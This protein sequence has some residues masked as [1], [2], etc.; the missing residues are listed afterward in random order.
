MGHERAFV[1]VKNL[2]VTFPRSERPVLK[3]VSFEVEEGDFTLITG[4]TGAGKTTL[5][6]TLAG[7]IPSLIPAKVEGS[8][9]LGNR[10]PV[11]E[12]L[13][14]MAGFLGIV[15]QDPEAQYVMP[16]VIEEAYFPA[17]N[18]LLPRDEVARRAERALA[19][20][21]LSEYRAH[22]V[23]TLSTGLKQRLAL[24]T[25]LVLDPEILL[26][27]E[28]TAHIDMWTAREI[29]RVL[30]ELKESGKTILVVEHRIELAEGLAD[31]VVYIERDGRASV[32]SSVDEMIRIHGAERLVSEGIWVPYRYIL[33]PRREIQEDSPAV[34]Q[35]EEP[36]VSVE[37]LTVRLGGV[38]VLDNVTLTVPRGRVA[39]I[40]GPNGSGKTTLLKVLSGILRDFQGSV[41]VLG[42]SPRPD[43]V[44]FVAQ[45][46]EL[47][48]TER[49]VIEELASSFKARGFRREEALRKARE[50]LRARGIE[51]LADRVVYELS[52]GEKR[53]ISIL[54]MDV[55]EREVYLLDEP[56]FGLDLR[57]SLLV[58]SRVNELAEE[59]KTVVL[60]THDSWALPML[61][62]TIYGLS[63]G[64]VVFS[65]SL[66]SLLRKRE[67]WPEL[68]FAPPKLLSDQ[69]KLPS[70][71]KTGGAAEGI[72]HG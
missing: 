61:R 59:G 49:T 13:S 48:F 39:V 27:D 50:V 33:N 57:Y 47:Q 29:Y 40:L 9:R 31:K 25:A 55:L 38:K 22:K 23:D 10:D 5:L 8:V 11:R 4:P 67:L 6:L 21:G 17:E 60:V 69:L 19:L 72:S 41:R 56:T 32:Y 65:G 53:L 66:S 20:V 71:E 64:R 16:T 28:P 35:Q 30:G 46:P 14:S 44:A 52:Q 34:K 51:H 3:E 15:F 1:D 62:A 58:I 37:N 63:R 70:S 26:L 54:E 45:V 24:S 7:V 18:L 12:G 68:H 2:K 43:K 36:A 42:G